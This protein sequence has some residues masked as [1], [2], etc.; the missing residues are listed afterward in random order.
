MWPSFF[1]VSLALSADASW[2]PAER[3]ALKQLFVRLCVQIVDPL[4]RGRAFR[5]VEEADGPSV[6]QT[7]VTPCT[8][9]LCSYSSSRSALNRLPRRRKRESVAVMSLK[10]AASLMKVLIVCLCYSLSHQTPYVRSFPWCYAHPKRFH[11]FLYPTHK[12]GLYGHLIC[13]CL[14]KTRDLLV[15]LK[16]R[17]MLHTAARRFPVHDTSCGI[18]L[19]HAGEDCSL[20]VSAHGCWGGGDWVSLTA[21]GH[22]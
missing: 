14:N 17:L 13:A 9:S 18:T 2:L 1:P 7:P 3:P 15:G 20:S 16:L 22:W 8:A 10:A 11:S 21:D 4:S 5:V 19:L 6:P 12:H